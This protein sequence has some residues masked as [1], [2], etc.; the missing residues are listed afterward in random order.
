MDSNPSHTTTNAR[1]QPR[2]WLRYSLSTLMIV[3]L[4]L[5]VP[6]GWHANQRHQDRKDYLALVASASVSPHVAYGKTRQIYLALQEETNFS[7]TETPLT[8]V[9]STLST[10]H[11]IPI[12]IDVGA[13]DDVGIGLDV[14]ITRSAKDQ[15]LSA[16]LRQ[17]LK[18]LELQHIVRDEVV[19]ITTPEE[20]ETDDWLLVRVYNVADLLRDG[21]S[22]NRL[23]EALSDVLTTTPGE[24]DGKFLSVDYRI[25]AHHH[26]LLVRS[27]HF[28]HEYLADILAMIRAGMNP[29]Q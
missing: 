24:G 19:L 22:A 17:L 7:F 3:V 10:Q 4:V 29:Q 21:E 18:E 12:A 15:T 27:T 5:C 25:D 13:L 6:L 23:A 16:A 1:L 28:G 20:A 2:R 14:P 9:I 8:T 26:L 11:G